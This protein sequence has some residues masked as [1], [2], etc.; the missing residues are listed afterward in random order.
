MNLL[1]NSHCPKNERTNNWLWS[2]AQSMVEIGKELAKTNDSVADKKKL[3]NRRA[4]VLTKMNRYSE[5]TKAFEK[6]RDEIIKK[7]KVVKEIIC[8]SPFAS[9][10]SLA[11]LALIR[12]FFSK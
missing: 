7:G 10:G 4:K 1:D 12:A 6:D 11:N 9:D 5:I 2:L 8:I 3:T